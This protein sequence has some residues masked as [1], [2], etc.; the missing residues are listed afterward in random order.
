MISYSPVPPKKL[1]NKFLI[2]SEGRSNLILR[3]KEILIIPFEYLGVVKDY[4][5]CNITQTPD[6]IEMSCGNYIRR[7]LKSH[8]W[9]TDS[10]KSIPSEAIAFD[11]D[12]NTVDVCKNTLDVSLCENTHSVNVRENTRDVLQSETEHTKLHACLASKLESSI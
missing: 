3:K 7:L 6:Y 2:P 10:S 9:D 1:Q 8:G 12:T 5:G 11:N 4:N